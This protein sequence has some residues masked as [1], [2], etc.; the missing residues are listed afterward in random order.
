MGHN[1]VTSRLISRCGDK[2]DHL[3][4]GGLLQ[5]LQL[6]SLED[7]REVNEDT[8]PNCRQAG[9]SRLD[10]CATIAFLFIGAIVFPILGA[11]VHRFFPHFKTSWLTLR[12]SL[13]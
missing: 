7:T 10:L 4:L 11:T 6:D 12:V 9:D 13:R 8:R 3:R 5:L 1:T 2:E